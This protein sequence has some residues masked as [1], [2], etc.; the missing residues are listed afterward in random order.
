M[1]NNQTN[2]PDEKQFVYRDSFNKGHI[3]TPSM[4]EN[5]LGLSNHAKTVYSN[6]LN[7]IYEKGHQAF[8]STYKL[9]ISS[10][11]SVNSVVTYINELV[12]KGF[13]VKESRGRGRS[14]HYYVREVQEVPLLRV[15][16][17]FWKCMSQLTHV[18]GW[19]KILP[20]KEKILKFMAENNYQLQDMNTDEKA[21]KQLIELLKHVLKGGNP[22]VGLL[23]KNMKYQKPTAKNQSSEGENETPKKR[24][25]VQKRSAL[26][27]VDKKHWGFM[28]VSEWD[29]QQFKEYYYDKYLD[30]TDQPHPRNNKKHT[31]MM[32]H[33]VSSMNGENELLKKY[34]DCVFEIGY[35]NVTLDYLST[36]RLGEIQTF[37]TSGKKPFYLEKKLS[38]KQPVDNLLVKPKEKLSSDEMIKKML[39]GTD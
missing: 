20:A 11:C 31:G 38:K 1:L 10:S 37:I 5:C 13:I 32:R 39:G 4:V 15:S 22:E 6:I 34:I 27:G 21:K 33:I 30:N 14:N 3:Q 23:P 18:Y 16:E 25:Q 35:D 7:H 36:N 17:M 24:P 28:D 26:L 8:P 12:D 19:K 9:A 29:V 2:I